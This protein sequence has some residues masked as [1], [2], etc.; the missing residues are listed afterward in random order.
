MYL[1]RLCIIL[2]A[3]LT[4]A[5]PPAASDELRGVVRNDSGEPL[6]S[7]I[8]K[9]TGETGK[10]YRA[11]TGEDG[12]FAISLEPADT[13]LS[14][15]FSRLGYEAVT[16][17]A[18]AP[19]KALTVT[20]SRTSVAL[21]EV[22]V[23]APSVRVKG[24]TISYQLADFAGKGDVTLQDALQKVPGV[25]VNGNGA[26]KYNGKEISN[27][28]ING[29]DLLGGKYNIATT[30][31]PHSYV[32]TVEVLNNHE[33]IKVRRGIFSDNVAMNIRLKPKAMFKPMGKYEASA[34][35]GDRLRGEVS[36]AGMLFTDNLQSIL[37][38]KAGNISEFAAYDNNAHY[39][40]DRTTDKTAA[41]KILGEM[42]AANPPLGR[43]RWVD[44]LDVSASL[45]F[46][47][48]FSADATL[49][50]NA[51]YEYAHTEYDY[52]ETASYF[53]G[54]NDVT[55]S[56]TTSPETGTHRPSLSAEYRL[57]SDSRYVR[58]AL[59]A[60]ADFT[61]R[62]IPVVGGDGSIS[63]R[64]EM[65]TFDV[66]DFFEFSAKRG[67]MRWA[68]SAS[69]RY[70]A[71]P[72]GRIEIERDA[73]QQAWLSQTA[74]SNMFST[75]HRFSARIKTRRSNIYLPITMSLNHD[76]IRTGLDNRGFGDA[77]LTATVNNL[78][79]TGFKAGFSPDYEYASPYNRFVFR[80]GIPV[81]LNIHHWKNSGTVAAADKRPLLS[82]S[83]NIYANY[84]ASAKSTL[85]ATVNYNDSH[86]DILEMLT[87]P[88]MTDYMSMRLGSGIISHSRTLSSRLHYGFKSPLTQWNGRADLSYTRGWNNLLSGQ[89]VS[90]GLIAATSYLAPNSHESFSASLG[91]A[92]RIASLRTNISVEGSWT[93]SRRLTEQNDMRV[94][95][96]GSNYTLVPKLNASP[97]EWLEISYAL[98]L[99]FNS[100]RYRDT[101]HSYTS[102]DHNI[103]MNFY[104]IDRLEINLNC[105]VARKEIT[106]GTYKTMALF[107]AGAVFKH[108][109]LRLGLKLRNLLNTDRYTY[110]AFSG[111]DSYTYSYAL[112]GRELLLSIT[113]V[114]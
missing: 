2:T 112:R 90:S 62:R 41:E 5:V 25:E 46:M 33:Y 30:S 57:N 43:N 13:V 70:K 64:Q 10:D 26:L 40:Q 39:S 12:A 34:G 22:T 74:E 28:Y 49:R 101:R 73:E 6:A 60:S 14:L 114:R 79:G 66:S 87:A 11:V 32:N 107:D 108:K 72:T 113:F 81:G 103:R 52:S 110:T 67:S 94:R 97:I 100:T 58:N 93:W 82:F 111:L 65:R 68:Y 36:G 91:I 15:R 71:T 80:A 9:A 98:N 89:F 44:P 31:I 78:R 61:E 104:P 105:D 4:A 76:R 84:E 7:V 55:I 21:R 88:V 92:K 18:V 51:G 86:G 50:V 95:Y 23:K 29:M 47:N 63:Q 45:N 8:V 75:V 24:D 69:L 48:K 19:Y 59:Y 106:A 20:M 109:S 37:T 99:S 77:D 42:S 56:R 53:G 102:Q 3:L 1:L 16:R 38:V 27:F 85:R 83:P 17:K 96:Y 54:E 35:Y